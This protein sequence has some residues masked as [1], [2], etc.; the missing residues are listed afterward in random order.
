V[1]SRLKE[2]GR[3][4]RYQRSDVRRAG[5]GPCFRND[6]GKLI[7]LRPAIA[8]LRLTEIRIGNRFWTWRGRRCADG[9]TTNIFAR[10][11]ISQLHL[12]LCVSGWFG[13]RAH[14]S[15]HLSPAQQLSVQKAAVN[16]RVRDQRS[17]DRGPRTEID[18]RSRMVIR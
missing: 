5:P 2:R 9:A 17:A 13:F 7:R 4:D 16:D 15:H 18:S 1:R 14:L 11:E 6:R 10:F 3:E 12:P 8:G